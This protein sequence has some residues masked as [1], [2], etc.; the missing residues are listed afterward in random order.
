MKLLRALEIVCE[1]SKNSSSKWYL[2]YYK[3]FTLIELFGEFL[4]RDL[5][6]FIVLCNNVKHSGTNYKEED[7]KR[8][9]SNIEFNHYESIIIISGTYSS[10]ELTQII[11]LAKAMKCGHAPRWE[12]M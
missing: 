1:E 4:I 10:M 6:A 12:L 7:T 5:E 9:N 3:N 11:L 8:A 2:Q